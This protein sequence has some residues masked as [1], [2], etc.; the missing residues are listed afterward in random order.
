M[1]P[2]R[3]VGPVLQLPRRRRGRPR[4]AGQRGQALLDDVGPR[5]GGPHLRGRDRGHQHA[6]LPP[7][8]QGQAGRAR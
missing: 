7:V 1:G 4:R 6:R 2:G 8:S 5:S 3:R